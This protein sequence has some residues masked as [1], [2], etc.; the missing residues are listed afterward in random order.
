MDAAI[1]SVSDPLGSGIT[2]LG[3]GAEPAW[4]PR[5]DRIAFVRNGEGHTHIY[6]ANSQGGD[7]VQITDGPEDER[8]PAWSPDGQSHRVLLDPSE[9]DGGLGAGEPVHRQAR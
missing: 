5:G 2:V 1:S 8:Q 3:A 9:I 6:V 4:S 7:A